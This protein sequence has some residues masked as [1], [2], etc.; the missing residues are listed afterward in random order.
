[1]I[2]E[3]PFQGAVKNPY[4]TGMVTGVGRHI[5]ENDHNCSQGP[6]SIRVSNVASS[7]YA[8]TRQLTPN[9]MRMQKI[10]GTFVKANRILGAL[11]FF[12]HEQVSTEGGTDGV[13]GY[14]KKPFMFTHAVYR[15]LL[16]NGGLSW[17]HGNIRRAPVAVQG[18]QSETRVRRPAPEGSG[19]RT[20]SG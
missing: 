6:V 1:M 2:I 9:V 20:Q 14:P 5:A 8:R 17:E 7:T 15:V 16:A 10:P 19:P 4:L 11:T 3:A 12:G 18:L 13:W